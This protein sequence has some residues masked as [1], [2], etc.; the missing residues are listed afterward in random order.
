MLTTIALLVFCFNYVV[1]P[2]NKNEM[3]ALDLPKS[4]ISM[5]MSYPL[6]KIL[7]YTRD[8]KPTIVL[9]DSRAMAL[10]DALFVE[11]GANDTYNFAFGG[12][13][14]PEAID[15]FWF[16]VNN[17]EL[18]RVIFCIPF[19]LLSEYNAKNRFRAAES[20]G[21][22]EMAY[23][24]SSFVTKASVFNL[25]KRFTGVSMKDEKPRVE[26]DAFWESQLGEN[27]AMYY[28]NWTWSTRHFADLKKIVDYCEENGIELLFIL[29]P[30]HTDLQKKISEY[31]LD[32]E[33][34]GYKKELR[35]L[36]A[37]IDYD[38]DN[39]VT[40]NK[41]NFLDPYHFN[42]DIAGKIVNQIVGAP[43]NDTEFSRVN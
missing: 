3:F 43:A 39:Q 32:D 33:Y 37:V 23:Y 28:G 22:S 27:T 12:G 36:G 10:S 6:F 4:T 13:T 1:D 20:L 35:K 42:R 26:K 16:A 31:A 2:F 30:S 17:A 8:P 29:P 40:S 15:T 11:A 18:A 25:I 21:K 5:K 9:G 38:F 24:F 19:N 41:E 14:L 7:E 34:L